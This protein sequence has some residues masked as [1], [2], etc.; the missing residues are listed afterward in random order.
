MESLQK[1]PAPYSYRILREIEDKVRQSPDVVAL[2]EELRQGIKGE[3]AP[4]RSRGKRKLHENMFSR[5]GMDMKAEIGSWDVIISSYG[6]HPMELKRQSETGQTVT[7][8]GPGPLNEAKT[9][10]PYRQ[11]YPERM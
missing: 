4:S 9:E 10:Q 11:F 2:V 1:R 8:S 3:A 6:R 7:G 5:K